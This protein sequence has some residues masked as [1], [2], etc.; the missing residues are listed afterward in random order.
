MVFKWLKAIFIPFPTALNEKPVD[1]K[2][3][4]T[5]TFILHENNPLCIINLFRE[6]VHCGPDPKTVK[7]EPSDLNIVCGEISVEIEN[8]FFSTEK[9]VK[10]EIWLFIVHD[11][12]VWLR[13]SS[14]LVEINYFSVILKN[15]IFYGF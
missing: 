14:N 11:C 1:I 3:A 15:I 10:F 12:S 4:T 13:I 6:S 2:G 5:S 7:A 9:E 8:Q